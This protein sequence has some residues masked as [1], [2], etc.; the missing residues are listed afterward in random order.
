MITI[1]TEPSPKLS[2][3]IKRRIKK[4]GKK[5]L[6]KPEVKYSGHYAVTRSL[7]AGLNKLGV[8]YQY[9]P[10]S[11]KKIHGHV[12]VLAGVDTLRYAIEQKRKGRIKRLTAII[13]EL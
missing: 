8:A 4:I 1:L 5:I 3:I 7:I 12:H 2:H 11:D 13:M 9:N 10:T 6:G